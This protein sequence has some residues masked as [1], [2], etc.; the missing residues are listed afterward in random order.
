MVLNLLLAIWLEVSVF[1]LLEFAR[2]LGVLVLDN[3]FIALSVWGFG[4][5]W[6]IA[7]AKA[8]AMICTCV[9]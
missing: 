6:D 7:E 4:V 5:A 1:S 9:C 3:I 2:V 8:D